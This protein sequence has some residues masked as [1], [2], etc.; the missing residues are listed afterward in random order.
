MVKIS[1]FILNSEIK[2]TMKFPAFTPYIYIIYFT[3]LLSS[4]SYQKYN[5]K[6]GHFYI[7]SLLFLQ[8]HFNEVRGLARIPQSE[9]LGMVLTAG[10]DGVLCWFNPLGRD[11]VCKLVL[12]VGKVILR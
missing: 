11:P 9:S 2:S 3:S 12:K 4:K 6:I 5:I 7:D 10:T 8:G 1:L